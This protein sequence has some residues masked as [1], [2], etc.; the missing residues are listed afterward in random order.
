MKN[1]KLGYQ[2]YSARNDAAKDLAGV[3]KQ[4]KAMGYDGVEMAGLY[5]HS[6]KDVKKMLDDAGLCAISAHIAMADTEYG[7][8]RDA[9]DAAELGCKF[10][11]V[12]FLTPEMRHGVP[13]FARTI[14]S[15]GAFSRILKQAGI[16]LLYHNHDFEFVDVCG[17]PGLD[18]MYA[19]IDEKVLK[20]ELDVCWIKYAGYDPAEYVRKYAGRCP[21]VHLKDYM[22]EHQEI[23]PYALLSGD[24]TDDKSN[25]KAVSFE[26]RP[27]GY[28]CQDIPAI[29]KAGLESGA[30]WFIV[31]QDVSVGRT[32]LEAAKM[33]ADY[34][35]GL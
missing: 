1:A 26:F 20:T 8:L 25:G 14:R 3:L 5:G 18:F 33:S 32:A 22:G 6:A 29:V 2:V 34:V 28:G 12:P 19:A 16:Q 7:M 30:G 31:E 24:G 17:M 4:L 11:A 13:G 27:V 10:V 35:N 9:A 15:I 23:P 21:V